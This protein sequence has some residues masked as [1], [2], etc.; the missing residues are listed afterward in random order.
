M[1]IIFGAMPIVY[2]HI[3]YFIQEPSVATSCLLSFSSSN[4]DRPPT[5]AVEYQEEV[6]KAVFQIKEDPE[7][8]IITM[9]VFILEVF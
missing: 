4:L 1:L 5:R 6:T 9:L 7:F 8:S 3:H 2:S